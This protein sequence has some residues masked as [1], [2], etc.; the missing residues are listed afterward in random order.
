MTRTQAERALK[1]FG[2]R[3][4]LAALRF[5]AKGLAALQVGTTPVSFEWDAAHAT[6]VCRALVYRFAAK[7]KPAVLTRVLRQDAA[8]E[9]VGPGLFMAGRLKDD[10][11]LDAL[12]HKL[13]ADALLW[14]TQ[15]LAAS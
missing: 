10:G 15:K 3:H 14:A 11:P 5:N 1:A 8:L 7:P 9:L 12:V 6:L 4:G 2:Q 13:V